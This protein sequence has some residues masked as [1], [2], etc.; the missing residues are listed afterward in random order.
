M[1]R[2]SDLIAYM[3][4]IPDKEKR[5]TQLREMVAIRDKL[6][7]SADLAERLRSLSSALE[8]VEGANFVEKAKQ[9]LA[10]VSA[11]AAR[12]KARL[13]TGA[14]FDRKQADVTLTAIN[15][16]LQNT[17][18]A[19]TKGWRTLVDEQGK[20]YQPL[21]EAAERASLPGAAA[22]N[23]AIAR[24]GDWRDTPPTS[25][26]AAEVYVANAARIPAS[27]ANLGLEGHAGKFMIDAASGR[28]KAKD[29]QNAEVLA[30]LGANPAVWSMLKVGL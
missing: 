30:F 11:S 10:Q 25:P 22:L 23:A 26:D 14:G 19:V 8:A 2:I 12:F 16:R 3:K 29:L 24:L 17:S 7:S 21:A 4:G 27:I 28:A 20:R 6:R 9:G 1:S 5:A 18:D 15:E 13:E